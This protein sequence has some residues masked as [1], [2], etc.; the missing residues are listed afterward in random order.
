VLAYTF[1]FFSFSSQAGGIVPYIFPPTRLVQYLVMFG[2]FLFIST[3]FLFLYQSFHGISWKS[4]LRSWLSTA[5]VGI[6]LTLLVVLALVFSGMLDLQSPELRA[7]QQA[8]DVDSWT[9]VASQVLRDRLS[10]PWLFLVVSALIGFSLAGLFAQLP[11]SE[12]QTPPIFSSDLFVF[13]LIFIGLALSWTTEFFYLLDNFSVRL[14][15]IFKFYFQTW[16]MLSLASTY[17]IWWILTI[18]PQRLHKIWVN[19]ALAGAA[20]FIL[21]GLVYPVLAT[22]SRVAGL[23]GQPDLDAA[24]TL[25]RYNP[26]DWAAIDWLLQN[27][28]PVTGAHTPGVPVIL[29]APGESYNYEGRISAFTGFPTLLGWALHEG[30]WR[31]SYVEQDKRRP[32]ILTIFTTGDADQALELLRKW[33][34]NYVIVGA[35]ERNY[36]QRQCQAGGTPCNLTAALRKFDAAFEAVFSEGNTKIYVVP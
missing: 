20:L 8:L 4:I 29:E 15:T 30:Q 25:R 21:G 7:A 35:A 22:Q 36:I 13:L 26:E 6:L 28:D 3:V 2:T 31:G 9:A 34:V 10:E 5:A 12:S 19:L 33:Q 16:I 14:N 11:R 24:S 27:A 17:A 1:F 32:D 23:S 18:A